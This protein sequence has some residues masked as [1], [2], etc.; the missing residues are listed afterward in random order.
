MNY[1]TL[2]LRFSPKP[3]ALLAGLVLTFSLYA[4]TVIKGKVTDSKGQAVPGASV[5]IKNTGAG[6]SS[7]TDGVYQLMVN[8]KNGKYDVVISSVGFKS[9]EKTITISGTTGNFSIDASL[10][11]DATGLDEVVVTGTS[12]GT[13]K[14]QLG[15]FVGTV[16]ASQIANSASSNAI[17]SLQGKVA[18]AQITQKL[19]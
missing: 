16:K 9:S 1:K 15:N 7:N 17:A 13:T 12:Q 6:T 5:Q 10:K 11:E 18:G 3:I 4:Q 14:K 19:W 2:R 8:L